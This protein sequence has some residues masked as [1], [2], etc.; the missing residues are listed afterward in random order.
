VI[1]LLSLIV[2]LVA[3]GVVVVVV[4]P[5]VIRWH[6]RADRKRRRQA[7]I[8]DYQDTA[9]LEDLDRTRRRINEQQERLHADRDQ[10][11]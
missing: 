8:E 1:R 9:A 4:I 3:I 10:T 5:A 2:G 11:Q 7:R 6:D